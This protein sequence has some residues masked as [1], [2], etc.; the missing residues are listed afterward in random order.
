MTFEEINLS[1]LRDNYNKCSN[2]YHQYY[3]VIEVV[4]V[5]VVRFYSQKCII[6]AQERNCTCTIILFP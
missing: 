1:Y 4:V 3:Y 5:V 6:G 2:T